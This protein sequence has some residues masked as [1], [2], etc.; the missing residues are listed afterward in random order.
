MK[1]PSFTS[2]RTLFAAALFLLLMP[3]GRALAADINVDADCSLANAVLSANEQAMVAPSADC[4]A[5][6]VDDGYSQVDEDGVEIPSGSDTITIQFEGTTDGVITLDGTLSVTSHIA[7]VG[8]GSVIEGAGNQIFDVTAGSLA[9]ASLTMR[10]GWSDGNGGAIAVREAALSLS[11]SVVSGSATRALGGGIYAYNSDLSLFDSVVTG[12]AT[13]VLT[14]PEA[15]DGIAESGDDTDE[16]GEAAQAEEADE[17]ELRAQTADSDESEAEAQTE[18][19]AE[20]TPEQIPWDTSGGGV[21]FNGEN[22]SL[23]IGRSGVESNRSRNHGGGLYIAS[24]RATITNATISG[25]SAGGSGGAL[26]NAGDSRLT[27]VTLVFNSAADTG[28]IFDTATLQLYNSVVADNAG[29][30]CS[31]TLNALLGNLIRDR[32]CGHDGLSEDPN[33]L[34]LGGSPAYYLPQEG[35]PA[36]DAA[37]ADHC[38]ATDQR[39]I[40]RVLDACDI[41]AAEFEQGAFSFQIQSALGVISPDGSADGA[42]LGEEEEEEATPAPTSP[43]PTPL[44]SIC[45]DMPS[46]I[47]ITGYTNGT[48]CKA[49]DAQGVGN[50]TVLSHGFFHA[51]DIFGDLS[52]TVSACFQHG[53]GVIILLDAANSPRNIV[54]LQPRLDG[55]MICADVPRAG[56]VV[57]MPLQFAQTGLAPMPIWHLSSCTVT[58]TAILN[59]RSEPNSASG[60]LANVLNNVQLTADQT[61]QNWYRVNYYDIVGWLSGDYLSKSGNCG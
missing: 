26:Y 47:L 32:S 16:N 41:G 17:T 15:D 5:G 50:Q 34:L 43:P 33:L 18:A 13:G 48:A 45:S 14:R 3:I 52:A 30:D 49:L 44:P 58:T 27:H 2:R 42:A 19:A 10:G 40:S 8:N 36:V 31:G 6:D 57:L 4:E 37:S 22:N 56:T 25:N 11:N 55:N 7:I 60:I 54:P 21:Y 9:V 35:S 39:G 38:S 53:P 28:G 24:G 1:T 23:V 51:V 20:A 59:L 61:E 12:N 29:G 46:N